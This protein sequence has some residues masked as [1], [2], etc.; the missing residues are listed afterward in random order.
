MVRLAQRFSLLNGLW[1]FVA[2]LLATAVLAATLAPR[3]SALI[4]TAVGVVVGDECSRCR[5]GS[6]RRRSDRRSV[7]A[8]ALELK[9]EV[10]TIDSLKLRARNPRTH[11]DRQIRKIADSI[12][13]F[14]FTNPVLVDANR[15]VVAGHG[16]IAAAKLL[17][18]TT[19]PTIRI[20]YLTEAEIRAYVIADN[21]LA[22]IAGWDEELLAVELQYLSELEFDVTLTGFE[23]AEVD[24]RIESLAAGDSNEADELPSMD[25][26]TPA[27]TKLGDV[28][29]L[30]RH[31]IVCA[32]ATDANSFDALLGRKRARMAFVD[33]PYNVPINGHVSG[34]GKTKHREFA[35]ASG[36]MTTAEYLRFLRDTLGHLASHTRDGSIHFICIDWRHVRDVVDVGAGIYGELKNLCAWVKENAGMGSLYRSQHELILVFKYGDAPHVNNVELGRYGRYRTNVWRYPGASALRS[37]GIEELAMHPTVKPVALVK[38]AILDCSRRNDI[39]LDCFGGSGT[40]LI[41][42]E[43]TGRRGYL[44]EIDPLYVDVAIERFEK[45]T[46]DQ[47]IHE[48][49]GLRYREIKTGASPEGAVS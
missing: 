28:W 38:D 4:T 3:A 25:A 19:L 44:I 32:S 45:L 40:T 49:T 6:R 1:P 27:V 24:L 42:A 18:M 9:V 11:T 15:E 34:M 7:T 20:D 23:M 35:M 10:R 36:E 13:R 5:R 14:G 46:G 48:A 30:G 47:A 26:N 21:R 12:Q 39:V 17:G 37:G 8:D 22:E 43:K 29:N 41:A 16:R 31:R 2:I 33:P